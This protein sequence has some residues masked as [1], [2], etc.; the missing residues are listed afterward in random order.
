MVNGLRNSLKQ[1]F[2]ASLQTKL[3]LTFFV[4]LLVVVSSFTVYVNIYVIKP[5]QEKTE[6]DTQ[7][8]AA[9]V[10]EQLDA[11]IQAQNEL[12]QR[13]LANKDVFD[14]L[15]KQQNTLTIEG[16]TQSRNLR[17]FMF[18]AIGPSL[19]IEDMIIF[20]VDGRALA[21][22]IGYSTNPPSLQSFLKHYTKDHSWSGNSFVL[23]TGPSER[24]SFIRAI[25]NQNGEIFG[26]LC[27][28]LDQSYLQ[29]AVDGLQAVDIVIVDE[30][31]Q[32][33]VSSIKNNPEKLVEQLHR[34]ASASGL[35]TDH[36]DN[37][38]AYNR[39]S[40][41][42][43][44]AYLITP[45]QSVLGPVNSVKMISLLLITLLLIFSFI[46]IYMSAKSILLPI[47][48]LRSQILRVSYSNMNVKIGSSTHNNELIM[49]GD[50]FK[51]LL[52]RLQQ[53][54]DNERTALK[55]EL[56]ARTSAL[57]AQIA[58]HFI[59]NMLYLISIAAQEGKTN[60][61]SEMCNHLSANLRYVVSSP[62]QH[63]TLSEELA[64]V[65]HY[66]SLVQQKYEDDL[67]WSVD[68]DPAFEHVQLPRLV[69]QPFVENCIEH[70][71]HQTDPPW[72]ICVKV[73]IFNGLWAIEISDNG[74]GFKQE[75]ITNLLDAIQ[76]SNYGSYELQH[77]QTG[78]GNMGIMNTV[79]RL[80]LMYTNRLF[81]HIF[82]NPEPQKGATIQIIGSLS[83]DFY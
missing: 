75:Q 61:V 64:H 13:I 59:H 57:Q 55:E 67:E 27:I 43:W 60:V 71:F 8:A 22:Y 16:L 19:S 10:N 72:K 42:D 32:L 12:S 28:Q 58:P 77:N 35:Y 20:D 76:Q 51:E 39:S 15:S 37:Y 11:Y 47:R 78:I 54:I 62:F 40:L 25:M 7:L 33:V 18:Q 21:A 36:D 24:V 17:D 80:K 46:Y 69:I 63:V 4:L 82:N 74:D 49:L 56:K 2:Q 53:S 52:E 14:F 50:A 45:A 41:T 81:F 29:Q 3:F 1:R 73:K 44:T 34:P 26:Y 23:T 30:N 9:K 38:I 70:A 66:L 68:E 5:L 48:K 65:K 83:K 31:Q 79:N 6:T